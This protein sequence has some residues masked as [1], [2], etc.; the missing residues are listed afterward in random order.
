MP[1]D[2]TSRARDKRRYTKSP[3]PN[4]DS[5]L[6]CHAWFYAGMK[7]LLAGDKKAAADYFRK[8]LATDQKTLTEYEMASTEL[9]AL[10]EK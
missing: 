4:V 8:C 2:Q 10:G 7:K 5:G 6:H 9:K 3:G 1:R